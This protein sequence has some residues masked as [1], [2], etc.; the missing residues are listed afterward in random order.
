M[1]DKKTKWTEE[2]EVYLLKLLTDNTNLEKIAKKTKKS[3]REIIRKL[4]K[5]AII[6]I[7]E[8]KTKDEI[9]KTL[10]ILTDEQINKIIEKYNKKKSKKLIEMNDKSADLS[11][12]GLYKTHKS[13]SKTKDFQNDNIEMTKVY[14]LLVEIDKKLNLLINQ[15]NNFNDFENNSENN[16]YNKK[17]NIQQ[18][19]KIIVMNDND[20]SSFISSGN[21][22]EDVMNIIQNRTNE[23]NEIRT[24]YLN[25]LKK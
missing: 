20:S 18:P 4:K 23:I 15:N 9:A 6:M 25:N 10:R 7:S 21:D 12:L 8:N 1:S 5:F 16:S 13:K 2:N 17:Q 19:T 24:K 14:T 11:D 3:E 22:T